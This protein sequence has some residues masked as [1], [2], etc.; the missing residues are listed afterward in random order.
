MVI[1]SQETLGEIQV[2]IPRLARLLKNSGVV[3]YTRLITM[4]RS[5]RDG[6]MPRRL[7]RPVETQ[8]LD[9]LEVLFPSLAVSH[10]GYRPSW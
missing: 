3:N 5:V 9:M 1:F 8:L 6:Y 2:E 10:L 4:C 7:L